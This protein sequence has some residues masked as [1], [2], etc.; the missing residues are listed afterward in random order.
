MKISRRKAITLAVASPLA[1]V[2]AAQTMT[3]RPGGGIATK[4]VR[5]AVLAFSHETVGY[6]KFDTVT[7][8]F[9]YEGSPARGEALLASQPEGSIGGFV[10][11]AREFA[12]VQLI[13]IESP[14]GSKKGSGSGWITKQAFDHFVVKM[15]AELKAQAPFDAVYMALHGA[16]AVK[17]VAKPEAEIAKRVRQVVGPKAFLVGTF[18]PHGNEDAEFLR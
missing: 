17:D 7:D 12:N 15:I 18:D 5:I 11:V 13:G 8:D 1:G 16:M 10:K 3:S 14:L 9:I 6:L 2:A 4:P